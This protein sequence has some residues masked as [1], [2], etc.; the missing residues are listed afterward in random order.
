MDECSEERRSISHVT[1]RRQTSR[2]GPTA[3]IKMIQR[4]MSVNHRNTESV[5]L[6]NLTQ[7]ITAVVEERREDHDTHTPVMKLH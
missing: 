1:Y 2:A 6:V 7:V 4:L 3:G 5:Q